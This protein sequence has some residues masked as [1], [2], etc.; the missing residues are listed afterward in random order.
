MWPCLSCPTLGSLSSSAAPIRVGTVVGTRGS[1]CF[2][3]ASGSGLVFEVWVASVLAFLVLRILSL[4]SPCQRGVT[5]RCACCR[6]MEPSAKW[7][8]LGATCL[9]VFWPEFP[10][11]LQ[12]ASKAVPPCTQ[13]AFPAAARHFCLTPLSL[14]PAQP[15]LTLTPSHRLGIS[16]LGTSCS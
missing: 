6:L 4:N 13:G 5:C 16:A 3:A 15:Q 7:I 1:P 12:K 8:S 2:H 9:L 11:N 14:L 10:S